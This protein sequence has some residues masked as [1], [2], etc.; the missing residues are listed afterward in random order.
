[1]TFQCN[2]HST[3]NTKQTFILLLVTPRSS[4]SKYATRGTRGLKLEYFWI[5]RKSLNKLDLY[6]CLS[7][8]SLLSFKTRFFKTD[9]QIG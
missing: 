3:L 8:G 7:I 5:N 1:M 6:I 4:C 9:L 2:R